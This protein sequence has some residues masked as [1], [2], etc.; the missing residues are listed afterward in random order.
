[1]SNCS[2]LMRNL[3]ASSDSKVIILPSFSPVLSDFVSLVYTG[4]VANLGVQDSD[5]LSTLCTELGMT[6]TT[7]VDKDNEHRGQK[8]EFLKLEAEIHNYEERFQLRLPMSRVDHRCGQAVNC[9]HV[10]EGFKG[11]IQCTG[12][13]QLFSCWSL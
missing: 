12:G 13:I 11:R 3:L 1:M 5:L 2:E 7:T 9:D 6:T 4:R 10:F 8:S